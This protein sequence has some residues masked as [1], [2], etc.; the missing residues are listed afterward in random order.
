MSTEKDNVIRVDFG[1]RAVIDEDAPETN[2]RQSV[3]E[4]EWFTNAPDDVVERRG[5]KLD[6][7]S[8]L[9]DEGLVTLILDSRHPGVSVPPQFAGQPRL[10]L[11]FSFNFHIDDFVFDEVGVRATLSFDDGDH[12]TVIPWDA[13]YAMLA[14][15]R[16]EAWVSIE[17]AP[18][19]I[20]AVLKAQAEAQGESL[21]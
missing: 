11:N 8:E 13:V 17:D 19:E 20:Q 5:D 21:D 1:A 14:K 15:G 2:A 12:L 4:M 9:I 3:E 16:D 7:F 6:V 18:P 10:L